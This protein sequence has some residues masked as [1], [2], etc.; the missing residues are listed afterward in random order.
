MPGRLCHGITAGQARDNQPEQQ[1]ARKVQQK[2]GLTVSKHP[3]T[4]HSV[5]PREQ[6]I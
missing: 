5:V 1:K 6:Q 3:T 2:Q 4:L